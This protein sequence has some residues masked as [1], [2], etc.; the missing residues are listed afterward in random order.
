MGMTSL[1]RRVAVALAAI[2]G[3]RMLGLFMILP[4][5]ALYAADY[6]GYTA[7]L[8]GIA[9]GA[10]GLAQAFLQIPM[11][12]LSDRIGRKPVIAL[13]L[14][15][16][17]IGSVV[18]ANADSMWEL[19]AGRAIQG[20]GA[21]ASAVMALAADLTR[22]EQ[23]TKV[24][25]I[26]GGSIGLAFAAALV[27]GPVFGN[28]WGLSGL[29]WL[30]A[31]LAAAGALV[32]AT[33]VPEPRRHMMHRDTQ[34]VLSDVGQVLADGQLLRLDFGIFILHAVLMASFVVV[35][36]QLQAN[37]IEQASHWLV[38]LGVLLIAVAGMIPLIIWA[39]RQHQ[40]KTA[41]VG[42]VALLAAALFAMLFFGHSAAGMIS[43]LAFMFLGFNYLE[44]TLPS[45]IS[46]TCPVSYKG[47]AMGV[48]STSQ[49]L[50]AFLG[51]L[52]GGWLFEF[53]GSQAVFLGSAVLVLAWLAAASTMRKPS[54]LA[55]RM[56][57]VGEVA[58]EDA[59]RLADSLRRVPGVAEAVVIVEEQ[60]AYLKVDRKQLDEEAL[61]AFSPAKA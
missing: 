23:R 2:F 57:A 39:E 27:I 38:Y 33:Q 20:A 61:R 16:F 35:P 52:M 48:Y 58:A 50:G 7:T 14:L 25:A 11:G 40:V 30:T 34:P 37:G 12:L 42:A 55:S 13:G 17:A 31:G 56:L 18:A 21:I 1:E 43:A 60:V 47:T 45:L 10:Y 49:F 8:A 28:L 3:L 26:I 24:M 51:G 29:F 53:F 15:V 19:I 32:L 59:A 9:V 4:V 22:D 44:A 46:K 54:H 6:A 36:L 41:F 5:I